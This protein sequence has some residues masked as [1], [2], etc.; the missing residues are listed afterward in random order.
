M[1]QLRRLKQRLTQELGIPRFRL[2]LLQDNCLL[3][4]NQTLIDDETLTRIKLYSLWNWS[5]CLLIWNKIRVSWRHVREIDE[6]LLERHL[7]QPRSP[8]FEDANAKTPLFVAASNGRL[9]CRTA[10]T[11]SRGRKGQRPRGYWSKRLFSLLLTRGTLEVVR[12]LVGVWCQQRP[13]H[14]RLWNNASFGSS[15]EGAPWSCP[16]SG[17]SLAPT[18]I[19]R[20]QIMDQRLF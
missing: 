13:R 12:F 2:R 9:K 1:P 20:A 5:F 18:K 3:D 17:L 4:D 14:H 11:W 10:T 15:R 19:K 16:I 6:K 8:N 7:N